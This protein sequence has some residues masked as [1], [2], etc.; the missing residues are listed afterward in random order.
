MQLFVAVGEVGSIGKAADREAIAASA[1]SKRISSL[2][3]VVGTELL[4]RNARGVELTVAGEAFFR[5][6]RSVMLG[7]DKMQAELS[8][9]AKG[10]RGLVRLRAN[11]SAIVQFLPEDLG[12]F[13]AKN[14]DVLIDLEEHLSV[15]IVR[16]VRDGDADIGICSQ[17][18][19]VGSL[20][21]RC[22]RGDRL[23]LVVPCGH[24]LAGPWPR[25]FEETLDYSYVCPQINS[26]VYLDLCRAAASVG[27]VIQVR[28]RVTGLDAMCRMIQNGL[29]VGIMPDRA[30]D[31]LSGVGGLQGVPLV[32][33][34]AARSLQIVARDFDALPLAARLLVDHLA[35]P[36]AY[37]A[38]A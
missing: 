30:F 4:Y 35:E 11:A 34:W 18:I 22:Y 14:V 19:N 37:R 2:E 12:R 15:D 21:A 31:L 7:L 6:A 10:V 5:H 24:S 27:R 29:G 17:S 23:V 36:A 16:L 20:R 25:S 38:V 26:A 1:L 28:I 33:A 9:Y 8:D 3:E 13:T 32:D